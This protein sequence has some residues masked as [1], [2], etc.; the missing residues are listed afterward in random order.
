MTEHPPTA[1]FK[2]V[3]ESELRKHNRSAPPDVTPQPEVNR[4]G[5]AVGTLHR[6]GSCEPLS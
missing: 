1:R 5:A 3:K 2:P 6:D 4:L